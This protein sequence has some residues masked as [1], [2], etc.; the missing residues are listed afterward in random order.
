M[1][2]FIPLGKCP[3]SP[4][5][6]QE[7]EMFTKYFSLPEGKEK[8]EQRNYIAS[9]YFMYVHYVVS[10][11][12]KYFKQLSHEDAFQQGILGLI[13]AIDKF[14]M[15][16]GAKFTT[17]VGFYIFAHCTRY[18]ENNHY[19]I[20][21]PAN[22]F[23]TESKDVKVSNLD[24]KISEEASNTHQEFLVDMEAEEDV[25]YFADIA[26]K[27][28]IIKQA[29]KILDKT[30]LSIVTQYYGYNSEDEEKNLVQIG[31][32]IGLSKERVRQRRNDS[33]KRMKDYI[34]DKLK[35]EVNSL[36]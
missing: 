13:D 32:I 7:T 28:K 16:K 25:F 35:E 24:E 33:I 20:R 23:Y 29:F 27:K 5:K 17:F 15:S 9:H 31:E 18:L 11:K 6:E 19:L 4:T 8:D 30:D 3:D 14:D 36:F 2:T 21:L 26:W 34:K 22:R 10:K 1:S 12:H